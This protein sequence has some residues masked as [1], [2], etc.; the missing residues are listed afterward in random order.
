VSHPPT[1]EAAGLPAPDERPIKASVVMP[2]KNGEEYLDE[3]MR[4][5]FA[6]EAP[7]AFEVVVVDSGSTDRTL[8]IL[9]RYP[10]TLLHIPPLEFNHGETRNFAIRHTRGAFIALLTQD[11]TPAHPGWLASL[12]AACEE[13]GVAGVF[14][15]HLTRS[16]CDPIEARNLAQHFRNFGEGRTRWQIRDEADYQARQGHYDFFSNC[17]SCLRRAAW[18]QIPFRRTSMAEDQMWAQD[19]LRAGWAKVY[20]PEASVYHSHFYTPWVFLMRSFDEFRSYKQLGNPGGYERLS[21][22]FPG[23]FK[24]IAKDLVYIRREPGLSRAEKLGWAWRYPVTNLARKVGSYLG[25]NHAR[26]P[27]AVQEALSLQEANRR[28]GAKAGAAPAPVTTEKVTT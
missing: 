1:D 12:V 9:G 22:I 26:L 23:V 27:R 25:T 16:D 28:R 17:N 10:V 5:I 4:A 3:V 15:P 2:T 8:E 7:F 6:Q 20:E 18:E 13:E 21:Q 14:G 19:V 24:E 11:A